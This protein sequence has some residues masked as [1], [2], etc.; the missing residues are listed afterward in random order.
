MFLGLHKFHKMKNVS[1]CPGDNNEPTEIDWVVDF[2]Q[3]VCVW[4]RCKSPQ[5]LNVFAQ[6]VAMIHFLFGWKSHLFHE[7]PRVLPHANAHKQDPK[8]VEEQ[9]QV[10]QS[11]PPYTH[12]A[13]AAETKSPTTGVYL[14]RWFITLTAFMSVYV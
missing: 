2:A 3:C 5:G 13:A 1:L 11:P 14:A 8:Y 4:E 9:T 12:T 7:L 6:E 10:H